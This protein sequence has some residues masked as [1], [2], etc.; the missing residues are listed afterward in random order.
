[1]ATYR[2]TLHVVLDEENC[3]DE[4]EAKHAFIMDL[5][6]YL[7]HNEWVDLIEVE[8]LDDKPIE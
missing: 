8:K 5:S 6:D 2:G 1:M 4:D 3:K 7:R